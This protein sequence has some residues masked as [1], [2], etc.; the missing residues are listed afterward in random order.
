M[1]A[2]LAGCRRA[3][4]QP[5]QAI[6]RPGA[7]RIAA[8]LAL[9]PSD[10]GTVISLDLDHLRGLATW[11]PLLASIVRSFGP[12]L[13]SLFARTGFEPTR[14]VHRL[15]IALPGER[16]QTE[17]F[18]LLADADNLDDARLLAWL[19]ERTGDTLTAF[20]RDH[21]QLVIAAGA[22]KAPMLGLAKQHHLS[23]SA[24]DNLE[25][26]RLCERQADDHGVWFVSLVTPHLRR[27][28]V[29]DGRFPDAAS[30][31]RVAG[32]IDLEAGLH[33]DL[34]GELTNTPDAAHLAH[35]LVFFMNQAKRDPE[36]LVLGLAPYL[37]AVRI[38][39]REA[40]VHATLD[41]PSAQFADAVEHIEALA[42]G[43]LSKY[44]RLP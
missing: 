40:T 16:D 9:L 19:R 4:P 6:D 21:T 29:E 22:W 33:V 13:D 23:P 43:S 24:A 17:R 20:V 37:E 8:A 15:W 3:T 44:S 1:L 34:E 39:A 35:R 25:L 38:Q 2:A 41:V 32:H 7:E 26:R 30:I 18:A 42:H 36:M 11:N 14:H 28:L 27:V 5:A 12:L 10:T 31:A